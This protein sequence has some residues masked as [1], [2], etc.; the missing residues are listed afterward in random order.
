MDGQFV[1][2]IVATPRSLDRIDVPDHVGD[3]NVR[4]GELFHISFVPAEIV[5][6]SLFSHFSHLLPAILTQRPIRIVPD[7]RA[8]DKGQIVVEQSRQKP[9]ELC[10]RLSAEAEKYEIMPRKNGINY[11]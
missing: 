1:T 9:D 6:G 4:R 3:R 8:L 7:F 11:L 10:F 2:D 5:Y